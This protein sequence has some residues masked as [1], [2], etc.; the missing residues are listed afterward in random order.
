[1]SRHKI[2]VLP[3][4]VDHYAL[5]NATPVF[6]YFGLPSNDAVAKIY[7]RGPSFSAFIDGELLLCAGVIKLWPG[8]G[9]AWMIPTELIFQYKILTYRLIRDH[10]DLII[11][12]GSFQRVQAITKFGFTR[13]INFLD[14][15]GFEYEGPLRKYFGGEDYM[16]WGKITEV[17]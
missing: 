16:R 13:A 4:S 3:Y 5:L 6:Q 9:D 2:I 14:H 11:K 7:T 12:L 8:V 1:M 10:L 15:L 17:I